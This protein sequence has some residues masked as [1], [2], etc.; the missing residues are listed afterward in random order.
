MRKIASLNLTVTLGIVLHAALSSAATHGEQMGVFTDLRAEKTAGEIR[1]LGLG[2]V[3][4]MYHWTWL[5]QSQGKMVWFEFDHWMKRAKAQNLKVLIVAQGSPAWANGGHGPYDRQSG[6]NTPPLPQFYGP[7]SNYVAQL[8]RHGADAIEVWNEPNAAFWLPTPDPE[9][10]AQLVVV[11]YDAVKAVNPAVPVITGGVCPLPNGALNPNAPD[12]F[13][14]AALE[15]VPGLAHKFDGVG[16]HPYVFAN[17]PAAKDPLTAP[18]QWNAVLQ[19]T[20]MQSVLASRGAG[21][22]A[23]WFTEFGVPTGGPFGAVTADESGVI[24]R[25]YFEAFDRLTAQ[26][27]QLGPMFFWTLHDS[28]PYQKANTIEGWEG[29]YDLNGTP[30]A[31]VD[32]IRARAALRE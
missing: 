7:Y 12:K 4:V 3:R 9:A 18:Y 2:W 22:K 27:I 28:L 19:T 10:W 8:V 6:L 16:H 24:Y 26:G 20:A 5:E 25:H 11:S 32:V 29:I 30:K 23:F 1:D 14:K 21:D 17:A 13:L 31:S 15:S